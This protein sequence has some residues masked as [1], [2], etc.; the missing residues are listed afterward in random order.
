MSYIGASPTS[1]AFLTNSFS[2]D[3][4]TTSFTL[5]VAPASSSSIL[6]AVSGVLQ[7]PATYAV[8]GTSLNFTGA[9]PSGTANIIV[10]FLGIPA[11]NVATA[12]YR[13]VTEFTATASQ[14]TFSVPSYTPG[15]IDVY[16]N[17]VMLG[18][19][20]Y[21]ATNG[22][23]V[24][25]ASG[26]TA[27]DLVEVISF[28]VSSI[29]NAISNTAGSVNANNIADGAVGTAEIASGAV[30]PAKLSTG[31]PIW[32]TSGDLSVG[33]STVGSAG[34][35]IVNNLNWS[36]GSGES[37]P[38]IFRQTSSAS[39]VLASGMR[40]SATPNGYASSFSSSWAKTAINVNI[41]GNGHIGF[42]TDTATTVAAGTDVT[43]T[44]RMRIDSAG[45]VTTPY[46]PA[47]HVWKDNGNISNSSIVTAVFNNVYLNN[48]GHYSNSTGRFTAPVAGMYYFS[49]GFLCRNPV[50]NRIYFYKNGSNIIS[51]GS[52]PSLTYISG[53]GSGEVNQ[54]SSVIIQLAANDYVDIRVNNNG[55]DFY[56]DSNVHNHFTGY[57]L[58]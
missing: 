23:T 55:G 41:G 54:E 44:E 27:G 32:N 21:T 30:T 56:G 6:V 46:Q 18:S 20:D 9:P 40:Q 57:L 12:S 49:I 26:A 2:G 47:F 25:L 50:G 58:G 24:V 22:T 7:D 10:R 16:R 43:P 48:G 5:T 13:T 36:Q 51:G 28:Y 52:A 15:F 53:I 14:T 34:L 3:G 4:T 39:L 33:T 29:Y 19:A 31:A 45:R 8:V 42:F 17:G 37:I 11:S 1:A 38:N 35:T